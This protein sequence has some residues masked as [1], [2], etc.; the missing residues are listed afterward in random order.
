MTGLGASA[1]SDKRAS[2]DPNCSPDGR[3][4]LSPKPEKGSRSAWGPGGNRGVS[5]TALGNR[6]GSVDRLGAGK[7]C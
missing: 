7:G 5:I 2:L 6:K 3:R 4:G 1:A